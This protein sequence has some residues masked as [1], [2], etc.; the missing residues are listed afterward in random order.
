M[1]RKS[2]DTG[3]IIVFL[4][5]AV[6]LFVGILVAP[7]IIS[8][9]YSVF[10]WRFPF[11]KVYCGFKNY[12]TLFTSDWYPLW[13]SIK[14]VFV[15][16]ALS[17]LIQLPLS[18]GLALMLGRGIK[19]ERFF[20]SVNFLPVL[21]STV[22]IGLLWRRMYDAE[23]GIINP[24]LRSLGII[25]EENIQ[26]LEANGDKLLMACIIP[27]LWQ[28]VGYHMLLMYAGVKSVAPELREAA[29]IDGA[30]PWQVDRF[31]VIPSMKQVLKVSVIFS[32]TGSL[33]SYDLVSILAGD[34]T[35]AAAVPSTVLMNTKSIGLY[36]M[37]SAC[38]VVII[39]LC[40]VAAV[41]INA[42]FRERD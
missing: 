2:S 27:M 33:K 25:G 31:V 7:I 1:N 30:T 21:I 19:G 8:T 34:R 36:G 12:K 23:G 4:L 42:L 24:I 28:Y 5:P 38:A 13:G 26:W 17:L 39:I 9:Y 35:S 3:S 14:N 10:D 22:V 16:A 6:L 29:M 15:L 18:L 37:S 32:V 41:L 11:D 40:F 20:L